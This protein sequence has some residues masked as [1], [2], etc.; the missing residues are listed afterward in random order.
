[1]RT[2][3]FL[4]V[5]SAGCLVAGACDFKIES[6]ERT[7]APALTEPNAPSTPSPGPSGPTGG[8]T[9]RAIDAAKEAAEK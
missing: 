4:V 2:W 3:L 8:T 6:P 5:L 1:M 7:P 9:N